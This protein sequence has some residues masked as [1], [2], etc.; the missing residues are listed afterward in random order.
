MPRLSHWRGNLLALAVFAVFRGF[1]VSGFQAFFTAY[2]R[3]VGYSMGGIGGVITLASLSGA[4][5]AP[6]FGAFIDCYGARLATTLTGVILASALAFLVAPPSYA[7]FIASYALFM[8]SF[9]FG[10]PARATLLAKSVPREKHG[11]YVG[12][13]A[14]LFSSARIVGPLVTG[15]IVAQLGFRTGWTILLLSASLGVVLFHLLSERDIE[16]CRSPLSEMRGAYR[17]I[18]SP[19]PGMKRVYVLIAMDRT[20]WSLWFPML[21]AYLYGSGYSEEE[22]G[23]IFTTSALIQ[24]ASMT[25]WGRLVDKIGPRRVLLVSEAIG[26]AAMVVLVDPTPFTRGLVAALFLGASIA[27]WVPSYNKLIALVS[28]ERLG[29][30]YASANSV[31]SLAGS[32]TPSIGGFIFDNFGQVPVF[33]L[34][35]VAVISAGVYAIVANPCKAREKRKK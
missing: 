25:L 6:G 17:R 22:V 4:L 7:V 29:E 27:A 12:L 30:A 8:L 24:A 19:R 33:G 26:V 2:M 18:L 35:S 28:P 11:Y 34:S 10:Q 23:A 15:F 32:F 13:L 5:L 21:S 31:R 16:R 14:A 20:G 1:S 9:V 3:H